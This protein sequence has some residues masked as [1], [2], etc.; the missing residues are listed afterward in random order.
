MK[1]ISLVAA[2]LSLLAA[3]AFAGDPEAGEQAFG[4]CQTCHVVANEDGEVLAGRNARNGPNLYG[5][6]G[7]QAGTVDGFRY[8]RSIVQA[9][10]EGLVW[11]EDSLVP[12]L[13]APP[14]F[15]T[16]TLGSRA[17][18]GMSHRV[19]SEDQARD[20]VAFLAQFGAPADDAMDEDGED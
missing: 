10:E 20:I 15:L 17:R 2:S 5:I 9:G 13:L 11:D 16:E 19:R 6:V 4:Q 1:K 12:Y 8:Q 14:G 3:P 7:R 18:S